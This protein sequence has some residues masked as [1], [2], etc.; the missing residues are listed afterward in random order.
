LTNIGNE[1]LSHH[2]TGDTDY[3]PGRVPNGAK[4]AEGK[5]CENGKCVAAASNETIIHEE[6]KLITKSIEP[7]VLVFILTLTLGAITVLVC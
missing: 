6:E 2:L 5:M 3:N 1:L 7:C 4:C